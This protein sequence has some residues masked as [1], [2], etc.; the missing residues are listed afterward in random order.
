[1]LDVEPVLESLLRL[2]PERM[3]RIVGLSEAHFDPVLDEAM[4]SF[5]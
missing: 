2:V 3:G 5:G 4:D 1:L